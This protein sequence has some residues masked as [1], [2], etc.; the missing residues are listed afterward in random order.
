MNT[1]R[2]R[3]P[4]PTAIW[5]DITP[6]AA[7]F[8]TLLAIY[9]VVTLPLLLANLGPVSLLVVL[10]LPT[11]LARG[12]RSHKKDCRYCAHAKTAK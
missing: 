10:G 3:R 11:A 12:Y 7:W 9:T 6:H 4:Q 2:T 5:C 8:W 1:A